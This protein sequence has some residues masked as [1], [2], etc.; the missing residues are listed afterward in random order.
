[1]LRVV[2]RAGERGVHMIGKDVREAIVKIFGRTG[3]STVRVADIVK[4][5]NGRYSAA[6][7]R[8]AC[9]KLSNGGCIIRQDEGY[10]PGV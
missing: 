9:E 2:A 6:D 4:E 7:V 5:L 8:S 3:G 1:M 10:V